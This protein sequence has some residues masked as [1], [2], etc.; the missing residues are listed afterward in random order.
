VAYDAFSS[1]GTSISY[2]HGERGASEMT[3]GRARHKME[4]SDMLIVNSAEW[5]IT[6]LLVDLPGHPPPGSSD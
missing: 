2:E 4:L 6:S 5:T 3:S 1:L